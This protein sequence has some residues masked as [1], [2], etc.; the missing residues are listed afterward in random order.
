MKS[1]ADTQKMGGFS[2]PIHN[3]NQRRFMP[4]LAARLLSEPVPAEDRV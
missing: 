1:R 3:R 2:P 4:S